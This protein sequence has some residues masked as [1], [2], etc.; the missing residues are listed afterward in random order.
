MNVNYKKFNQA[1]Q[2][3]TDDESNNIPASVAL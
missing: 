3:N 2:S 1:P